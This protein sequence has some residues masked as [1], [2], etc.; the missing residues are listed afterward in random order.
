M[1]GDIVSDLKRDEGWSPH[2]YQD[3]L[4]YWT[5]GIGFL[6]DVRRGGGLPLPVAEHWLAYLLDKI[7]ADLDARIPWWRQQP[8]DVRRALLNLA[9]QLGV[10]GLL[11]FKRMLAALRVGDRA[12]AAREALDSTWAT[13]TPA[14]A[15]RVSALMRGALKRPPRCR[16]GQ[17]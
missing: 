11:N 10:S 12:G 4:G 17:C 8:D 3:H 15:S 2:I 16:G 7:E 5:I 9:Y 1:T 14:R 13:Q 6:V